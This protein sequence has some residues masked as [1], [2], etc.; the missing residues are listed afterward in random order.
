MVNHFA[1][2]LVNF[3]L[4]YLESERDEYLLGGNAVDVSDFLLVTQGGYYLY[5]N[6]AVSQQDARKDYSALTNKDYS[7]MNL[8]DALE[9]F[10]S[11]LYPEKSSKYYKQFLLYSYLRLIDATNLRE[12]VK[13]YDKR[14]TYDLEEFSEYFR[15]PRL[16]PTTTNDLSFK[17]LVSGDMVTNEFT[18]AFSNHIVVSQIGQTGAI[19]IYSITQRE[20]YKPGVPSSSKLTGMDVDIS[21]F[22]DPTKPTVT[23]PIALS[24]TGLSII[25]TGPFDQF[26]QTLGKVWT[27]SAEAPFVFDYS[28]KL[29]LIDNSDQKIDTML[30]YARDISN[31]VFENIWRGHHNS[32]YRL[33]GLLVAYVER[34]NFVWET[35]RT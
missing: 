19:S 4:S 33:A 28:S 34:M 30:N 22:I 29:A 20:Y 3:N 12:Q 25:L 1:S 16:S 14:I 26:S 11:I 2:L 9:T 17:L 13:A 27:F 31:P 5:I 6:G 21:Q 23:R 24:E 35:K 7:P 18:E 32:V 15:S 8:P 10:H